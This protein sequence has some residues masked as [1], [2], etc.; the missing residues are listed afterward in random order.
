MEPTLDAAL[1][2]IFGE[3]VVAGLRP[4]VGATATPAAGQSLEGIAV[5]ELAAQARQHYEQAQQALRDG[6]WAEFGKQL[7]VLGRV[8]SAMDQ[9]Q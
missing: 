1:V 5:S 3:S 8:L 4:S 7:E 2:S 6:E 9:S